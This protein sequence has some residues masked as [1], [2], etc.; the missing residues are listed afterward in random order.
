MGAAGPA[1][2]REEGEYR[3][4]LTDEQRSRR[5]GSGRFGDGRLLPRAARCR[6]MPTSA[7]A[8]GRVDFVLSPEKI[9]RRLSRFA[10]S[11][12][13][14]ALSLSKSAATYAPSGTELRLAEELTSTR[15]YLESVLVQFE[16][17]SARS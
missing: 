4:Y 17:T 11:V 14:P 13:A 5:A 6:S 12:R 3:A 7:I 10:K 16:A 8:T 2:R 15:R 1:A 9:G